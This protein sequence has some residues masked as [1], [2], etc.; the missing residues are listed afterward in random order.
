MSSVP[1]A[2]VYESR[3]GNRVSTVEVLHSGSGFLLRKT[4]DGGTTRCSNLSS[5]PACLTGTGVRLSEEATQQIMNM[6]NTSLERLLSGK[7]VL[8]AE[9]EQKQMQ[10]PQGLRSFTL[11]AF[12]EEI[13]PYL[14]AINIP[15]ESC[16]EASKE[17]LTEF[18]CTSGAMMPFWSITTRTDFGN[19]RIS[20]ILKARAD[21][22]ISEDDLKKL[23]ASF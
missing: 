21:V 1:F 10:I 2:A 23:S 9:V 5:S 12:S 17:E 3:E 16:F 6:E 11:D 15:L 19:I 7:R 8:G 18:Y 4:S 22:S 20:R 14:T 13:R